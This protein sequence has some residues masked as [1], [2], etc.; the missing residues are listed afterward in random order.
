MAKAGLENCH[1]GSKHYAPARYDGH[2]I[3]LTYAC[4]KCWPEKKKGY[5]SDIDER[6]IADEPIESDDP[7][8]NYNYVGSR[9]HY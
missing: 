3:F 1:C 2:G 9:W 8:D 4:D 5:R 7:M 6:Y